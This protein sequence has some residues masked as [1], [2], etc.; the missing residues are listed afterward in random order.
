MAT[1]LK[2]LPPV[3]GFALKPGETKTVALDITPE[4]LSF[5]AIDMEFCF[6]SDEFDIMVGDS[7]CG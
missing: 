7:S 3:V 6:E 1:F 5:Y 4:L 2:R